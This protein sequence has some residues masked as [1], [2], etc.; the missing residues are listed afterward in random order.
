MVGV[1][2]VKRRGNSGG[3]NLGTKRM[4]WARTQ[5]QN[6]VVDRTQSEANGKDGK[7]VSC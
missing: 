2:E 6:A 4:G 7:G 3:G 1:G 5:A